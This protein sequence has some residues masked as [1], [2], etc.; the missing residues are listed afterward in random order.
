LRELAVDRNGARFSKEIF[1]LRGETAEGGAA[2]HGTPHALDGKISLETFVTVA[3][4][5]AKRRGMSRTRQA[6]PP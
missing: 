3:I 6:D 2:G 4:D 1:S 5:G